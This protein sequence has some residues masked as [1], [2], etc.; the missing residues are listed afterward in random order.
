MFC[1]HLIKA[2]R[3]KTNDPNLPVLLEVERRQP[4]FRRRHIVGVIALGLLVAYL[5]Y[6]GLR[7][8]IL[9]SL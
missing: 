6:L 3:D 1:I 4:G 7:W 2:I 9:F 5:L 8:G